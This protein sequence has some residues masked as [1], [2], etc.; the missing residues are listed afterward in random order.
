MAKPQKVGFW[1]GVP[2]WGRIVTCG[3]VLAGI[4]YLGRDWLAYL[5]PQVSKTSTVAVK[6]NVVKVSTTVTPDGT[7]TVIEEKDTSTTGTIETLM[8]TPVFAPEAVWGVQAYRSVVGSEWL[9]GATVKPLPFVEG[10]ILV[11][12]SF[13]KLLIGVK[14]PIR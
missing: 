5:K 1:D 10:G 7:K 8:S 4:G 6:K 3:V 9:F 2:M 12:D 14:I 11:N 13:N